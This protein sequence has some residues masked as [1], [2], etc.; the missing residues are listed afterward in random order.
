MRRAPLRRCRRSTGNSAIPRS[1]STAAASSRPLSTGSSSS[2]RAWLTRCG[3]GTARDDCSQLFV[4][5]GAPHRIS[6]G[7]QRRRYHHRGGLHFGDGVNI[8]A[9]LE[10]LAEQGGICVSSAEHQQVRDKLDFSFEDMGDQ[11]VKNIA[12]PVRTHR[13]MLGWI[14]EPIAAMPPVAASL[15]PLDKPSIAV[16]PFQNMS[17]DLEQE[18]FTAGMVEDIITGLSRI[19]WL[20]V[21]ARNSSFVY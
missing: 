14:A 7:H 9:R 1:P 2:L 16:L 13:I 19:K 6:H 4:F 8:V 5:G 17:G 11:Q 18:Y 15:P 3:R 10:I 20:F 21:I 12:G